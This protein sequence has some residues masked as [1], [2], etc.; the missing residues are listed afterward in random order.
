MRPDQ[1]PFFSVDVISNDQLHSLPRGFFTREY[2]R[3]HFEIIW[4]QKGKGSLEVNNVRHAIDNQSIYCGGPGQLQRLHSEDQIHGMVISFSES[5][6]QEGYEEGT[7]I[8]TT[9][10]LNEFLRFTAIEMNDTVAC[11]FSALVDKMNSEL[12]SGHEL[13]NDILRFYLRIVLIHIQRQLLLGS[14]SAALSGVSFLVKRF[15]TQIEHDFVE[16]KSVSD[17]ASQLCVTP[18]YLNQM[19]KKHLGETAGYF[20]RK[21]IITEAKRKAR[22]SELN[23]KEIAFLLGFD[24]EAHF[25]VFFKNYAGMNFSDYKKI[26]KGPLGISY[27]QAMAT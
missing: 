12:M 17:Y 4:I 10:M 22:H 18:N 27:Q 15:L 14:S 13:K 11:E 24:S 21:R 19:V 25:S 20:I 2:R 3:D 5:F 6:I 16:K 7:G 26:T 9:E 1:S 23:M 8:L